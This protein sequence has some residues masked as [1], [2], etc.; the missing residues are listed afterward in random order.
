MTAL[1]NEAWVSTGAEA[2]TRHVHRG[3][4]VSERR[5]F[6]SWWGVCLDYHED[7]ATAKESTCDEKGHSIYE[8]T[9][10]QVESITVKEAGWFV[11]FLIIAPVPHEKTWGCRKLF[12]GPCRV[13]LRVTNEIVL[14]AVQLST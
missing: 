2:E 7:M 5:Y 1:Q 14:D 4:E 6:D 10:L 8:L 13:Q 11:C 3:R 12:L 9:W